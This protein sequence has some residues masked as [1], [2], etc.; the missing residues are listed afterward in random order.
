MKKILIPLLFA[1]PIFGF[2]QCS[3][4]VSQFAGSDSPFTLDGDNPLKVSD[5]PHY[6]YSANLYSNTTGFK[7]TIVKSYF[8]KEIFGEISKDSLLSSSDAHYNKEGSLLSSNSTK[9]QYKKN[10]IKIESYALDGNYEIILDNDGCQIEQLR[11]DSKKNN[12]VSRKIFKYDDNKNLILSDKYSSS[13]NLIGRVKYIY[14]DYGNLIES[15]H[16]CWDGELCRKIKYKNNNKVEEQII[17]DDDIASFWIH[18]YNSAGLLVHSLW[19]KKS[20]FSNELYI[21][22]LEGF[23]Y[24]GYGNLIKEIFY[25]VKSERSA[26]KYS[27][28]LYFEKYDLWELYVKDLAKTVREYKIVYNNKK[29]WISIAEYHKGDF[30]NYKEREIEYY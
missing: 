19:F 12:L 17:R 11:F 26:K 8:A 4:N 15:L 13:N 7:K 28:Y 3:Y 22:M 14:N 6:G 20:Y 9:Y 25:D 5:I 21:Y 10:Y 18:R 23:E 27:D 2:G 16:Y 30:I 1:I 24:D 29:H